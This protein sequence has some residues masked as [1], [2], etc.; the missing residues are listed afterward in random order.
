MDK[1]DFKWAKRLSLNK[2]RR[3]YESQAEGL[4]DAEL[5]E[6]AAVTLY[7]RCKDIVAVESARNGKVRCPFCYGGK[8]DEVYIDVSRDENGK[9]LDA[10]RC[11]KCTREFS[12]AEYRQCYKREQLNMGGAGAAFTRYIKE[13]EMPAP[14]ERRMLQVDRLIHEYH[15][16][17]KS[18][19]EQPTRSVGPNLLAGNLTTV[20]KFLNDLSGMT[21]GNADMLATSGKWHE[22]K[23]KFNKMW[24]WD[25]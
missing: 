20:M 21:G 1:L 4:L 9:L 14:P 13:Y 7:L 12:Y 16:S 6:D 11:H 15:Y 10:I 25:I 5:L 3:L 23:K 2:L 24:N 22:E 18:N 17:L 8:L 19:P